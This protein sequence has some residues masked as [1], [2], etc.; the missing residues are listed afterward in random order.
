[1][2][3]PSYRVSRGYVNR[4][5]VSNTTVNQTTVTNVYNTTIVNNNTTIN[6]VT[7]VNKNV[8]GAVTAVPQRSFASAQPVSR[9]AVRMDAR[10]IASA[11]VNSRVAVA[12]TS[13]SACSE[14]VPTPRTEWQRLRLQSQIARS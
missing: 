3:V 2:Y 7:Y 10:Q 14:H 11:P 6:N 8:N 9:S 5:N 4:V 13:N 1:V 12:P